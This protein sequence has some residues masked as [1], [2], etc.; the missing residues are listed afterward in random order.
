M[1]S[2]SELLFRAVHQ[3]AIPHKLCY[4]RAVTLARHTIT[5]HFLN[6]P[7]FNFMPKS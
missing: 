4:T 3:F 1:F 2:L 5:L 6:L 7:V